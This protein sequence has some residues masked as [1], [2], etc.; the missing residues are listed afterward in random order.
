MPSRHHAALLLA[1]ASALGLVPGAPAQ[2]EPQ[3]LPSG[4]IHGVGGHPGSTVGA[5]TLWDADGNGPGAPQPVIGGKSRVMAGEVDVGAYESEASDPGP[6]LTT[7]LQSD[8]DTRSNSN[9]LTPPE[10]LVV[11]SDSF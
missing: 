6:N 3:W 4:G 1:I 2:C 11:F 7:L 9:T 10:P 8:S 5:L